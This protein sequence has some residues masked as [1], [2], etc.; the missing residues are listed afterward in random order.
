ME[1]D[2]IAVTV[3]ILTRALFTAIRYRVAS[4]RGYKPIWFCALAILWPPLGTVTTFGLIDKAAPPAS[5]LKVFGRMTG[6]ALAGLGVFITIYVILMNIAGQ[7][8]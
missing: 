2:P 3:A 4:K 7:F 1:F 5:G 8:G 6:G